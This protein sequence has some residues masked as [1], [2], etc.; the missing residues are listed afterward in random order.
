MKFYERPDFT[1]LNRH[2]KKRLKKAKF[3]DIEDHWENLKS[4]DRRTQIFD[5]RD[6][7]LSFFQALDEFI[8]LGEMPSM[9]RKLLSLYSDG[10]YINEISARLNISERWV[11]KIIKKYK[12]L[13]LEAY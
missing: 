1:E 5:D 8:L 7:V 10:I 4:H 12:L 6:S 2:W 9:H 11:L 3:P 13:I